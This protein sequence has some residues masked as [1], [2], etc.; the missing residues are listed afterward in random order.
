[1]IATPATIRRIKFLVLHGST[2][3][4]IATRLGTTLTR[5]STFCVA[6]N[7]SLKPPE[8]E[9]AGG[10]TGTMLDRPVCC[11]TELP[12]VLGKATRDALAVEALKR[13][14]SPETLAARVLELVAARHDRTG[15]NLFA[16]VLD[17]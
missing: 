2:V 12:I 16:A 17:Y 15:D 1:L 5:L 4:E 10:K 3:E 11:P 14:T 8:P 13:R 7:I 6:Q 9:Q